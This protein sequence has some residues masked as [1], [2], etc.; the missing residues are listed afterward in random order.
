MTEKNASSFNS[1]GPFGAADASRVDFNKL[2]QNYIRLSNSDYK[3][4]YLEADPSVR[5]I[6]G[7]RGAGKTL[8]LRSIQDYCRQMAEN[9]DSIYFTDIDNEP[10]DSELIT[11]VNLWY[12]NDADADEGWRRI[13]KVVILRSLYAH[14]FYSPSLRKYINSKITER[15]H[16]RYAAILPKTQVAISIYNQLSN[17]LNRHQSLRDLHHFLHLEEWA[18]FEVE[19]GQILKYAP[20][21]YFFI[22]QVDDDFEH[23][24]YDWL[25]CQY[26]LFSAVFRFIRN[27]VYG[28]RL[29]IIVSI[30][31]MVYAYILQTQNGNKYLTESK[32]KL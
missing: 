8:Y 31:E 17:L 14:F 5:I 24:P 18:E 10:P 7:K 11:K 6:V 1:D 25:K 9:G 21:V 20:P 15:F 30:R 3:E 27:Q 23:A 16:S 13:W 4:D 22:D 12:K 32:I 29:H 19:M 28:G 26:G 2:R